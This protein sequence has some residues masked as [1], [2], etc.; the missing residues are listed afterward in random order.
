MT[1]PKPQIKFTYNDYRTAPEDKRYELLEGELILVPSPTIY[2]QRISRRLFVRL[3]RFITSRELGEVFYS[4]CDV[5]LSDHDVLQPD[6]LYVSNHRSHIITAENIQGGPDLVVEILSPSTADR[7]LGYKRTLYARHGVDEYWVVDPE[8]KSIE[9]FRLTNGEF[10]RHGLYVGDQELE[11]PS[12]TGL[13]IRLG[14]V[15]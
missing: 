3:E 15:F 14:E 1:Q 10:V 8:G 13:S 5:V 7:D 4:P 9:V 11:S 6:L 12:L 2:H